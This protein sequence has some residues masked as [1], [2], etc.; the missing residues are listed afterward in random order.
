MS[1]LNIKQCMI[2]I[3]ALSLFVYTFIVGIN[4]FFRYND[5]RQEFELKIT[6]LSRLKQRQKQ[7][8]KLLVRLNNSN[9]WEEIARRRLNLTKPNETIYQFYYKEPNE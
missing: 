1:S 5:F 3:S 7:M 9:E 4:S 2:G 6:Q 8:S